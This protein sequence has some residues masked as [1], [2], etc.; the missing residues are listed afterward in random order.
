MLWLKHLNRRADE[1]IKMLD[2]DNHT[3]VGMYN[4]VVEILVKKQIYVIME[5]FTT[6]KNHKAKLQSPVFTS[7][8]RANDEKLIVINF[9][10]VVF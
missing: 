7:I 3:M 4:D 2:F 9:D 8:T 5:F 10:L 6:V 1:P